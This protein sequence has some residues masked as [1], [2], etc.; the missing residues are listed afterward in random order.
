MAAKRGWIEKMRCCL[1]AERGQCRGELEE[2]V[3]AALSAGI[4]AV[5]LREKQAMTRELYELA[6]RLREITRRHDALLSINDRADVALAVEADGVHLGWQSL[7]VA[8]VRRLVGSER[9]IGK[10]VHNVEEARRASEDGADYVFAGPVFDTPSKAGLVPTLG[11]DGLREICRVIDLPVIGLGGIDPSNAAAVMEA[12][13]AGVAVIR[14]IL[15]APDP[16][17]AAAQLLTATNPR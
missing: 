7:P 6:R 13:A 1:I 9:L 12:G 8:E 4:R 2:T 5:Q 14:A 3:E 11:L 16:A 15:A 17:E 10:S